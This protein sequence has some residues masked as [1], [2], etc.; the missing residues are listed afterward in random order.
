MRRLTSIIAQHNYGN[1]GLTYIIAQYNYGSLSFLTVKVVKI[2]ALQKV[3]INP[4][5]LKSWEPEIQLFT[6]CMNPRMEQIWLANTFVIDVVNNDDV[7][8]MDLI[9][10]HN[11]GHN[12]AALTPVL[13][14]GKQTGWTKT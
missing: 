12:D 5:R 1:L 10:N 3:D 13:L 7:L 6:T 14:F 4:L 9:L 2:S 8:P 11:I